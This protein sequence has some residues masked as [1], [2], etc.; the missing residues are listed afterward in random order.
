MKALKRKLFTLSLLCAASTPALASGPDYITSAKVLKDQTCEDKTAGCLVLCYEAA[1]AFGAGGGC[2]RPE[3]MGP[4]VSDKMDSVKKI[5]EAAKDAH[6]KKK[7]QF[8]LEN[9]FRKGRSL[10]QEFS[11]KSRPSKKHASSKKRGSWPVGRD[12]ANL[13]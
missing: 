2:S 3:K 9:L 1:T 12:P 7:L 8:G 13:R 5:F 6:P 11:S 10:G 4:A